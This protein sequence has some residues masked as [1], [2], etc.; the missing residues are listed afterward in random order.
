MKILLIMSDLPYPKDKSGIASTVGNWIENWREEHE[1]DIFYFSEKDEAGMNYFA[2][3]GNV[4][5]IH[6]DITDGKIHPFAQLDGKTL[7][8]SR[9][10]YHYNF[11][12]LQT[13]NAGNY[14]AIIFGEYSA[15]FVLDKLIN[16]PAGVRTLFFEAD[17]ASLHYKRR[18]TRITNPIHRLYD[19]TQS[20]IIARIERAAYSLM[21]KVLFVS[22]VDMRYAMEDIGGTAAFASIPIGVD[23]TAVKEDTAIATDVRIG[24][25]GIMTYVPN[26]LCVE[27]I[28]HQIVPNLN[29]ISIKWNV[30]LIG[31]NPAKEWETEASNVIVTGFVDD[32]C[33]ALSRL[34]IYVSPLFLG[35]GMKNKI[36]QAMG[37]GVPIIAS[38]VSAE[39]IDGLV[40][41]ENCFICGEN[42]VEW[43]EAIRKL[44]ADDSLRARF[45]KSTREVVAEGYTWKRIS[46]N[47]LEFLQD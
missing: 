20:A 11:E 41:G 38:V 31:K 37:V 30:F 35:T 36:I 24:F 27:Y 28:L 16:R 26:K 15:V 22:E 17:A 43:I 44:A 10:I 33:V 13:L 14:D 39:G 18:S 7:P 8:V 46:Q 42:P 47:V 5:T 1:I 3:I 29:S 9:N 19:V 6:Q 21:D 2:S 23:V 32:I 4:G 40:H 34:D 12:K 45:S 25:S